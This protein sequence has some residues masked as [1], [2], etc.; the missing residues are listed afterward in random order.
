MTNS[1]FPAM[2]DQDP[3]IIGSEEWCTFESLDIPAIKARVDSGAKTSAI[4]AFNINTFRKKRKRWVRFDVHPLQDNRKVTVTCELPVISKRTI[5]SSIGI[6]ETRFVVKAPITFAGDTWDIELTL[7]NRDTMGYRMLLGREAMAGRMLVDPASSFLFGKISQAKITRFYGKG[8]RRSGLKI[9]VLATN[10][11]LYSNKRLM[12]VGAERGHKMVFLDIS[13]CYMKLDAENPQVH[14]RGGKIID[15]LDAVITR[16]RPSLTFYG[17]ALAR[18]FESMDTYT[19][20]SSRAISQSRNKLLALQMMLAN[21]IDIPKTGFAKSL[22]DTDELIKMVNGTPLIMKLLEGT[23]GKGV[24]LAETKKAAESVIGAFNT[25]KAP[26]LVQEFVKEA[27]GA[28]L[29]C[30]VVDGIVV[31]SMQRKAAPGEFRA[32]LHR[33]GKASLVKITAEERKMAVRAAKVLGLKIAGVDLIRSARGPLVLEVNSSPGLEGIEKASGKDI[34]TKMFG[35]IE[36]KLG[37]KKATP[38]K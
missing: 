13:Q 31:A 2:S 28:D 18:Q 26:L 6:T 27:D 33:G 8:R 17:C 25:L 21:G 12:E 32:N 1:T 19:I 10:P 9:G 4:H 15:D 7:T 16:V 11:N 37:W 29:R 22:H 5:K 3:I 30:F 38:A 34:A 36:K 20:N 23:Q 14:Y 24:V 35:S